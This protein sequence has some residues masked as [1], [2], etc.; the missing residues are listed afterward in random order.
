MRP[1][2]QELPSPEAPSL[3]LSPSSQQRPRRAPPGD[4]IWWLRSHWW[5]CYLIWNRHHT[6]W[7][8]GV[9]PWDDNNNN[10]L[11]LELLSW[12]SV[13][14]RGQ[15]MV[16]A[17]API[18]Y[19][20]AQQHLTCGPCTPC[21]RWFAYAVVSITDQITI[22]RVLQK[23]EWKCPYMQLTRRSNWWKLQIGIRDIQ[24][25]VLA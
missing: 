8:R 17:P 25:T 3:S 1:H 4:P 2:E 16:V 24:V 12:S 5:H 10:N 14:S 18:P 7:D 11:N 9:L 6:G 13:C 21:A 20:D 15:T 22:F 19:S 23:Q